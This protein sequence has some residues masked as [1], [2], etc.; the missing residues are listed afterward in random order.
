MKIIRLCLAEYLDAHGISRYE[1]AKR[2]G[3]GYPT[4]DNYYKG[5]IVRLDLFTM[6]KILDA[7]DCDLEDILLVEQ[8]TK[9]TDD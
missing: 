9:K 1:L 6:G 8:G 5:K 7:L 2:T 3:I 4:I